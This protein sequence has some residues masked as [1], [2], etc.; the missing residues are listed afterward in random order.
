MATF[1][2]SEDRLAHMHSISQG[3]RLILS[4]TDEMS[5]AVALLQHE[6]HGLCSCYYC[7]L[8]RPM[9]AFLC[10]SW[11]TAVC[12]SQICSG[13]ALDMHVGH[14]ARETIGSPPVRAVCSGSH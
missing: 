13:L 6:Q 14:F 2:N 9:A 1:E 10:F 11:L 5:R 4:P 8:H 3:V 7:T 12:A